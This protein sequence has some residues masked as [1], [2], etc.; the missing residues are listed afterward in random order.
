MKLKEAATQTTDQTQKHKKNG[1]KTN[2]A[3]PQ[4]RQPGQ[5][6]Q[7]S[8]VICEARS[9]GVFPSGCF[10]WVL[11]GRAWEVWGQERACRT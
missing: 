5:P 8:G 6:A 2:N 11:E 9:R 4:P 10:V 7:A 3:A 1:K